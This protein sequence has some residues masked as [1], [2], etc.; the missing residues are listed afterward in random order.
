MFYRLGKKSEKPYDGGG[1]ATTPPPP[2]PLYVRGLKRVKKIN[3]WKGQ[4]ETSHA[5]SCLLG[6]CRW[7][8]RTTNLLV[9]SITTSRASRCAMRKRVCSEGNSDSLVTTKDV[10]V[11]K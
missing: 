5:T 1:E 7:Y 3:Y 4:D 8:L 2:A 9:G 6:I 11:F 10:A